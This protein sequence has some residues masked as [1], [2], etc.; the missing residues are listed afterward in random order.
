MT[1]DEWLA[2]DNPEPLLWH[3]RRRA[4]A[5]KRRL[6][7]CACCR[8]V[9]HLVGD[10]R[11]RQAVEAGESFADGQIDRKQLARARAAA[12]AR[13]DGNTPLGVALAAAATA[14]SRT[15][16]EVLTL[17]AQYTAQTFVD[18]KGRTG[19][20]KA[21]ADLVR[22]IVGNPFRSVSGPESWPTSVT[23]L[24]E[25]LYAGADC[26]FALHDALLEAGHADL[27][28]HFQEKEHPRGCWAL[29]LILGKC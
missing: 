15:D 29:D 20:R 14:L 8:R 1:E 21:Q 25:S 7:G 16:H 4:N 3:A 11:S 28:E 13:A 26:S 9:W 22:H 12:P 23:Q 24:A 6:V 10:R 27:A 5:R 17:I 19:E 2:S 18:K